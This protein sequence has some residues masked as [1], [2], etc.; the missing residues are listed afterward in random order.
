MKERITHWNLQQAGYELVK[1]FG[2]NGLPECV[3]TPRPSMPTQRFL[4]T[5]RNGR[6]LTQEDEDKF[7]R[8][9]KNWKQRAK[10][11][12]QKRYGGIVILIPSYGNCLNV[13]IYKTKDGGNH[14]RDVEILG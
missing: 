10:R 13:Y 12:I 3:P 5:L 7:K 11:A 1:I 9:C 8:D 2:D 4:N 6:I 14:E